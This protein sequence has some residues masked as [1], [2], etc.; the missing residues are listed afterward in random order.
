MLRSLAVLSCL[1]ILGASAA[2]SFADLRS[3][4]R[5]HPAP[6]V[7]SWRAGMP[8]ILLLTGED[9]ADLR[10]GSRA[11]GS[12]ISALWA[13]TAMPWF[14]ATPKDAPT[15]PTPPMTPPVSETPAAS[16]PSEAPT[17]PPSSGAPATPATDE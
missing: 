15:S 11:L 16:P 5:L 6:W 7:L 10:L 12:R 9:G 2:A 13:T 17:A 1:T 3:D 8:H 14:W 4:A